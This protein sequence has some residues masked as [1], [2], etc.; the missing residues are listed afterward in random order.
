MTKYDLQFIRSGT[1]KAHGGAGELVQGQFFT[2]QDFLVSLPIE[3]WSQASFTPEKSAIVRVLPSRKTK[4]RR[5]VR[6]LL[7]ALGLHDWGGEVTLRSDIW[8]GKGMASSTADIVAACLAV[9]DAL[10]ATIS[11]DTIARI[12]CNI[13]PTDG[14]MYPGLACFDH[15]DG[16]LI[17]ALGEVPPMC[18]LVVDLGGEVDTLAFNQTA[19]NYTPDE[20]EMLAGAY[21]LLAE[22]VREQDIGKIGRAG[23]ISARV[24]QRLLY[25]HDLERVI[26]IAQAHRAAGICIGHSGTI[27]SLLFEPQETAFDDLQAEIA[28]QLGREVSF[29]AARTVS[30]NLPF[31]NDDEE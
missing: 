9:G 22:G 31:R 8:E 15:V 23:T 2:Q 5:A 24:N 11:P 25:K 30:Q 14:L 3:L 6:A 18:V 21:A 19:K 16:M 26:A 4:T 13:E 27:V 1:G 20:L 17:D 28:A 10:D 7:D 12:A 29:L